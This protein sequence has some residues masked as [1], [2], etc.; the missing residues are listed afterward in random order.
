MTL[1]RIYI[2]SHTR[3]Y[4]VGSRCQKRILVL[5]I[6]YYYSILTYGFNWVWI[7]SFSTF[8]T[9]TIKIY[10]S[11]FI[12]SL[13]EYM[14]YSHRSRCNCPKKCCSFFIYIPSNLTVAQNMP[15]KALACCKNDY[16][17]VWPFLCHSPSFGVGRGP[18]CSFKFVL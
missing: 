12:C 10:R 6:S 9:L 18:Y 13:Q 7:F 11:F 17:K 15:F 4:S 2:N 3:T 1:S 16:Q 14:K 5:C 8:L